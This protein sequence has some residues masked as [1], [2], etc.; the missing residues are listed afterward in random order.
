MVEFTLHAN[1]L[2]DYKLNWWKEYVKLVF[3]G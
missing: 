3:R 2:D 1:N